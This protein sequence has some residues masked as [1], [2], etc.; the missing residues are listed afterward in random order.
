MNSSPSDCIVGVE[1][2]SVARSVIKALRSSSNSNRYYKQNATRDDY[3]ISDVD[4][5]NSI[6]SDKRSEFSQDNITEEQINEA[7]SSFVPPVAKS[8]ETEYD[9]S[10]DEVEILYISLQIH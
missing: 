5:F 9:S 7:I 1:N 4:H 8:I 6:V 3:L 10:D 2:F